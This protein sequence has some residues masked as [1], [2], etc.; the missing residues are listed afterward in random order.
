MRFLHA[1]SEL[2]SQ[3]CFLSLPIKN[4]TIQAAALD[5]GTRLIFYFRALLTQV[6]IGGADFYVNIYLM[7]KCF[8]RVYPKMTRKNCLFTE[9]EQAFNKTCVLF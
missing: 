1:H 7:S 4:K 5:N 9:L 2:I 3:R 8:A 6:F